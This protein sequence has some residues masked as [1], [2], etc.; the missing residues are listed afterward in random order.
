M[1]GVVRGLG[2]DTV[3][4]FIVYIDEPRNIVVTITGSRSMFEH[5]ISWVQ[6]ESHVHFIAVLI[7]GLFV[8]VL[9]NL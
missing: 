7:L 9:M 8:G 5:G 3:S 4:E 6:R 1:K 2:V